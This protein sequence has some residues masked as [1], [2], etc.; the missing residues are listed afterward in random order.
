M[1]WLKP[2]EIVLFISITAALTVIA[3]IITIIIIL[4]GRPAEKISSET[5]AVYAEPNEDPGFIDFKIPDDYKEIQKSRWY[6][7][8]EDKEKWSWDE[9]EKYWIDPFSIA[10]EILET[11]NNKIIDEIFKD[12]P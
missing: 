2:K 7:T 10:A 9:V 5:P 6:M 8:R 3:V 1:E 12:I 11:E 4:S